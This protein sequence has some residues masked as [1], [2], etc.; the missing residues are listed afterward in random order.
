MALIDKNARLAEAGR[1]GGLA[2][3]HKG[4]VNRMAS[5]S[6]PERTALAKAAAAVRWADPIQTEVIAKA[7]QALEQI[8]R[9]GKPQ[10]FYFD[11]KRAWHAP[12]GYLQERLWEP[13]WLKNCTTE[14]TVAEI[15]VEALSR[16]T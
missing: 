5:L 10:K 4:G 14:T 7:K 2:G 13:H 6:G 8:A 3:G 15:V 12:F 16:Y 1:K 11:G 9:D